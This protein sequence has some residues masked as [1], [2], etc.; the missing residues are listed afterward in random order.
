[1]LQTLAECVL[2]ESRREDYKGR[3][4]KEQ[5]VVFDVD[6][7]GKKEQPFDVGSSV[8][9]RECQATLLKF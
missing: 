1:M 5:L 3:S 7:E 9:E 6:S 8:G 2:Q 4:T